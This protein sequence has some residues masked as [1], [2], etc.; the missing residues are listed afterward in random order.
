MLGEEWQG[1]VPNTIPSGLE[2]QLSHSLLLGMVLV[3][4]PREPSSAVRCILDKIFYNLP[5]S[6]LFMQVLMATSLS[7]S[8]GGSASNN[9]C[10]IY[11]AV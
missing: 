1:R 10:S 3:F 4:L 11:V 9:T 2:Y 8:G 6:K 5:T 7:H